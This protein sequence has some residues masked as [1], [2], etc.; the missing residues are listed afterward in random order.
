MKFNFLPGP[1]ALSV[2]GLT[3]CD[4]ADSGRVSE[5]FEGRKKHES[6]QRE[7]PTRTWP[8][9]PSPL[10]VVRHTLLSSADGAQSISGEVELIITYSTETFFNVRAAS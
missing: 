9:A 7:Q 4:R 1:L 5:G 3:R 8:Y 6:P 2:V 10:M